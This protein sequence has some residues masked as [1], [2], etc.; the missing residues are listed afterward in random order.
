MHFQTL[1]LLIRIPVVSGIFVFVSL[2]DR[3]LLLLL[4]TSH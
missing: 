4:G 3:V 2:F 1:A